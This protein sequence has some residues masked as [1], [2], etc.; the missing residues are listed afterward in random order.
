M[1]IIKWEPVSDIDKFFDDR[2][3][4]SIFP[5]LGW[6]LAVDVYEE[7]GNV[8]A[9][10]NLPGV[11]PEELDVS[12]DEDMLT[13]SGAREEEKKTEEKDYYSKE[14]RRGSFS[15]SVQ[16]PKHVDAVKTKA[17]YEDGVLIVSMPIVK[18]EERKAVQVK[19]AKKK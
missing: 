1:A 16:L 19:V 8:C 4:S 6:D 18:G 13:I 5:K 9:K 3:I 14:I 11:N 2:S 12:V 15:R 10:M 7:K 17:E